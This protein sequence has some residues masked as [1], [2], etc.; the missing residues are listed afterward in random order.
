M[1]GSIWKWYAVAAVLVGLPIGCYTAFVAK[2]FWNW[3]AVPVLHVS[4]V[5]FLQMLGI[6]W[7][8]QLITG[9]LSKSSSED[10]RRWGLLFD[11]VE[12]CVPADKQVELADLKHY[13][14]QDEFGALWSGFSTAV[15]QLF[16]NTLMLG[17][18]FT[19]HLFV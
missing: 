8:L 12:L 11:V 10:D 5:S 9:Q 4:T 16:A 2:C 15:G 13:F 19:L 7:L 6:L 14:K 18:G 3:F 17:L 1:K